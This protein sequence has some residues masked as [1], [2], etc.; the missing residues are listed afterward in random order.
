MMVTQVKSEVVCVVGAGYVGLPLS[1]VFA[2][3]YRVISFDI[4][5]NKIKHLA[6]QYGNPDHTFTADPRQIADADFISICVPTLLSKG[7]RPDMS[8]IKEATATVGRYLKKGAIVIVE[9]SVYPG[10]TEELL[11]PILEEASGYK[12]GK[13]F[14][15]AYSPERINP[16]DS[17][18]DIDKITKIVSA[19]DEQTLQR[20]T[21]LYR[22]VTPHI[23]QARDIRTAEAAK[24]VENTQRDINLALINEFSMMF[25][26]MG[27]STRDVL[28]AA[29]TKWNFIK[30]SPGLIG[31]YCIP[32]VPY[33]L[34]QKAEEYGYH[35]EVILAGRAINDRIPRHIAEMAVKSLNN[36]GKVI[37]GSRVLIMGCTYKENVS[38]TRE[39]PIRDVIRELKEYGVEVYGFD[40]L[41]NNGEKDFGI[42][43]IHLLTQA[44]KMDCL[45]L[46]VAH[47]TFKEISLPS[48]RSIMNNFPVMIDVKGLFD[49]PELLKTDFIYRRM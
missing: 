44:P 22:H 35:P 36:V 18:H 39:T 1:Q 12:C 23:F 48:L 43:F 30:L 31:G 37:R 49:T 28:D 26:K 29:A 2:K 40:P 34:V 38:D 41:V 5:Y 20:V 42:K 19:C 27:L 11:K 45:I 16:G 8:H 46:N 33:F 13:D 7:K 10:A 47:D 24:L 25:D 6:E 9:S 32:V 21:E 14:K 15:I 3:G 17:E 4:D